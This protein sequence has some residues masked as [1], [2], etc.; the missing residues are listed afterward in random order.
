MHSKSKAFF[1]VIIFRSALDFKKMK[2]RQIVQLASELLQE[3][4][5]KEDALQSRISAFLCPIVQTSVE[6]PRNFSAT[7]SFDGLVSSDTRKSPDSEST[8]P[9]D[10]IAC[11]PTPRPSAS[12]SAN[13]AVCRSG[14]KG[15]TE[16]CFLFEIPHA[17]GTTVIVCATC[18]FTSIER[19]NRSGTLFNA[20]GQIYA[21]QSGCL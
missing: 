11:I 13:C 6:L 3:S 1:F 5:L 14:V 16:D 10:S 2:S 17:P 9:S 18:I 20:I 8:P 19:T 21:K 7:W 4:G 15:K 12:F